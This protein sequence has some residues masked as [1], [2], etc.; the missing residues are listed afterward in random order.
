V[1]RRL[2][3]V[4][5]VL[6][7]SG[8]TLGPDYKRPATVAPPTAFREIPAAE[9]ASLADTP[10][11]DVFDDPRLQEL[12]RIALVENRTLKLA[13]ERVEE[14]RARYGFT[15]SALAPSITLGGNGGRMNTSEGSLTHTPD[16]DSIGGDRDTRYWTAS[17]DVTWEIDLFGRIRRASEAEQALFFGTQEAQRGVVLA[18]VANVAQVYFE[19]GDFDRQLA[20]SRRT[21][22]SRREYLQLAQDRFDGGI[23]PEI[24][25]RQAEAELHRVE[26][27]VADF[28]QLVALK[29]NELSVLLGR[30]PGE[31]LR[32]RT[33]EEQK[34]PSAVPAGLPADLLDRRPD[35]REA[36]QTLA[37]Q[38]A[39]IGAAKALLFPRIAL[40]G[41]YGY[42]STDFDDLFDSSSKSWNVIGNVM[43][44]IFE[45]G[46]NRRRVEITESQQRQALYTYENTVLEAFR[47]TEDALVTYRRTGE[48]RTSQSSR[49][50]AER[51]VLELA[52]LRY[53]GGV[54]DYLEVLDA[55]RSLFDAEL[56]E[57]DT[58]A[59]HLISLVRLY[60]ALGGGWP[61]ATETTEANG[62]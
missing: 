16:G 49:V 23:T 18:L 31:V 51:K 33:V 36:E 3:A 38:T 48:Q 41:S 5:L 55:Q 39:N 29:E 44:P 11:W 8:C 14:A 7:A 42:A 50:V 45:G 12:I 60:K 20:I 10:W 59:T 37:A 62:D 15:R 54:A 2:L 17:A 43:Q 47:E 13:V 6:L 4:S 9:A 24:D 53:R 35:I 28:E 27:V 58:I 25:F 21:L 19:L 22:E 26:A 30:N 61:V 40:T 1:A 52:E 34:L 57:T 46:R 56:A 32:G